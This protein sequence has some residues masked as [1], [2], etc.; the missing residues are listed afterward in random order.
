MAFDKFVNDIVNRGRV[1]VTKPANNS[2]DRISLCG[3]PIQREDGEEF[4]IIPAH[5]AEYQSKL[6]PHYKFGEPFM[7]G[8][9]KKAGRPRKDAE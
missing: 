6:H 8:E 1:K 5:Q 7:E 9:E 4:F 3:S 2:D